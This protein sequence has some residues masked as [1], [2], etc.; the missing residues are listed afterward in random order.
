MTAIAV[1]WVIFNLGGVMG[2]AIEM[3][4][5]WKA[6]DNGVDNSTYI[7]FTVITFVGALAVLLLRD[8]RKVI[9]S[10]G[11]LVS[12]PQELPFKEEIVGM[13]KVLRADPWILL[14][15]PLALSSNFCYGFQQTVYNG[16]FFSLRTRGLNSLLYW[17]AQ[18][19]GAMLMGF[20]L[21]TPLLKRRSRAW[22]GWA[23]TSIVCWTVWGGSYK[24][25]MELQEYYASQGLTLREYASDTG[26]V[27]LDIHCGYHRVP[28]N[29]N[30][31]T[32]SNPYAGRAILFLCM[33]LIDA[34]TQC[35]CYALFGMLSNDIS[36]LAYIAGL[37]K[38][39][40][41]AGN[42]GG[43]GLEN[44]KKSFE[45]QLGAAWGLNVGGLLFCVPLLLWRVTNH[46]TL[47]RELH[48]E[49]AV[50]DDALVATHAHPFDHDL[51]GQK[52]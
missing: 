19:F 34:C 22:A 36:K 25:L 47:D 44:N 52:A 48:H 13:V 37:Y 39:I 8:P 10:D 42:V 16:Y 17:L 49:I 31:W 51:L 9:R 40:Q 29:D 11:T 7:A 27:G 26:R 33:G 28:C 32:E 18:M 50:A 21:D 20:V 5:G 43:W 6:E 41:S 38:A 24:V 46:T 15:V 3:G 14:I 35:Y 23:I 12:P 30:P 4:L 45:L 1:F 2:S